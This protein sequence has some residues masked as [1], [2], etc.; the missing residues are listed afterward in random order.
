MPNVHSLSQI[1]TI[2]WSW[3]TGRVRVGRK[4]I[5]EGLLAL[6]GPLGS[7]VSFIGLILFMYA[8]LRKQEAQVNADLKQT[9]DRQK[10]EIESIGKENSEL[11]TKIRAIR[12]ENAGLITQNA[13][14]EATIQIT[15][16]R[17]E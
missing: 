4:V 7:P 8:Y 12:E 14:L 17:G 6:L 13:V 2:S 16:L 11:E 10:D 5:M 3:Y 15:K 1:L 9:I